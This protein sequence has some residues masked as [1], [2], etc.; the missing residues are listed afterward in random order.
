M[1]FI[2]RKGI[3]YKSLFYVICCLWLCG[4]DRVASS[5]KIYRSVHD[6]FTNLKCN[7]N[8]CPE[9]Q[10]KMYG[11]ECVSSSN[12]K[13][14]RCS[15][16]GKNT[17]MSDYT[18]MDDQ[19]HGGCK[20][21]EEIVPESGICMHFNLSA[22]LQMRTFYMTSFVHLSVSPTLTIFSMTSTLV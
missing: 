22:W 3:F 10:C 8:N 1:G 2:S 14:C 5:F 15:A 16:K 6:I 18:D 4:R 11:A 20:R 21:D 17:F 7:S 19:I 13:Y 12:C 9:S